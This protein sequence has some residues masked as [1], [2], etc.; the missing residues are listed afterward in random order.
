MFGHKVSFHMVKEP[1][2]LD[3]PVIE[4]QPIEKEKSIENTNPHVENVTENTLNEVF[5]TQWVK[6][7]KAKLEEEE[8]VPPLEPTILEPVDNY[9]DMLS[10]SLYYKQ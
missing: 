7:Q 3:L 9:T 10:P 4:F 6:E 2:F 1:V 5:Q 8:P